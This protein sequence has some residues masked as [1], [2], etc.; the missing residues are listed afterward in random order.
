MVWTADNPDSQVA[1]G[2]FE[3]DKLE[4]YLANVTLKSKLA[5]C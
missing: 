4:N 5:M 1:I 2:F 3:M